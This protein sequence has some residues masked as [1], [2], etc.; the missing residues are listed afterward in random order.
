[1][2]KSKKAGCPHVSTLKLCELAAVCDS[3]MDA[4]RMGGVFDA[5]SLLTI[6]RFDDGSIR[7]TIRP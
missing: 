3:L 2:S 1:M 5:D 4:E 6:T 7:V